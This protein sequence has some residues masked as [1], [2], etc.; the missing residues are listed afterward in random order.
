[1]VT[2]SKFVLNLLADMA[3]PLG[4]QRP[5]VLAQEEACAPGHQA[6]QHPHRLLRARGRRCVACRPLQ[7][8][9]RF[10]R[11]CLRKPP[12]YYTVCNGVNSYITLQHRKVTVMVLLVRL[13]LLM[14]QL[15]TL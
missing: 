2:E 3:V 9:S 5:A 10:W 13:Q 4:N 6:S 1:M 14:D 12:V 15:L 7:A 8:F 11:R